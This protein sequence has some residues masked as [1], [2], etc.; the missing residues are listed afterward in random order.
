MLAP[1]ISSFKLLHADQLRQLA[2]SSGICMTVFLPPFIPGE[3]KREAGS[4]LLRDYARRAEEGLARFGMSK[5]R[6]EALVE[7]L[8]RLAGDPATGEGFHWSRAILRSPEVLEEFLLR[9]PTDGQVGVAERFDLLPLV[10]ETAMPAEF[11]VLKLSKKHAQVEVVQ[12]EGRAGLRIDPVKLPKTPMT[13]DEFLE[14]DIPDHDRENR[15][16]AGGATRIRFGTGKEREA[17]GGH[18][19]DFFKHVDQVITTLL[20]PVHGQVVLEGVEEDTAL[21]RSISTYPNVLP[22]SI[23]RSPD[24]GTTSQELMRRA[25]EFVR[26]A[27]LKRNA[28]ARDA[29]R[30]RLAPGRFSEKV[31]AIEELASTGRVGQLYLPEDARDA[32]LNSV[33]I[34]TLLH[35]GE[36]H[37]IPAGEVV[38]AALRY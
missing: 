9:H 4:A 24:D 13:M 11:Y 36:A 26:A 10:P 12:H 15:M 1:R 33:L 30:E 20:R 22:E 21:Y 31:D 18:L 2:G 23:Q 5:P 28:A 34:E 7:P 14:L 37:A 29:A 3:K 6:I 8:E 35:G 32:R 27:A 16:A 19:H 25:I 17:Q 38:G